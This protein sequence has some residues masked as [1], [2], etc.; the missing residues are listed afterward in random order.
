MA[1]SVNDNRF[2]I[3]VDSQEQQQSSTATPK[4][5][6]TRTATNK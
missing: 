5:A 4:Y 6:V 1:K 2:S 3:A